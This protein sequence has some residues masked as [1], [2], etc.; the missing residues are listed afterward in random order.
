VPQGHCVCCFEGR[1][2]NV[3]KQVEL[4]DNVVRR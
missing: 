2:Q 3:T 4:L 1:R